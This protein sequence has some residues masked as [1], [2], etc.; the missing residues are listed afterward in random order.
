MEQESVKTKTGKGES[1]ERYTDLVE[2]TGN[3]GS[4]RI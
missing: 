3:P 4:Y 2:G 1:F